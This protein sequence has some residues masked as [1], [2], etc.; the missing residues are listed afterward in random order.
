MAHTI[1]PNAQQ[2]NATSLNPE[3]RAGVAQNVLPAFR[4]EVRAVMNDAHWFSRLERKLRDS[5]GIPPDPTYRWW[6]EYPNPRN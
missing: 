2:H 1:H 4:R 5:L 6:D 3:W